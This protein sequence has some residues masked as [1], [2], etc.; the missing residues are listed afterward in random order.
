M[1]DCYLLNNNGGI[2]KV[3]NQISKVGMV[4]DSVFLDFNKDG[5]VDLIV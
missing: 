2:Y 4:T 3:E 5:K 1:P